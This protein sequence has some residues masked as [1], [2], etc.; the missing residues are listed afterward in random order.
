LWFDSRYFC[1]GVCFGLVNFGNNCV[2]EKTINI[3]APPKNLFSPLWSNKLTGRRVKSG[4]MIF[5][6]IG[7]EVWCSKCRE[8][9]PADTEFFYSNKKYQIG[10]LHEWCKSCC[11]AW[12]RA[13]KEKGRIQ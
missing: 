4:K 10:S 1:V 12:K 6:D 11:Q 13:K 7:R 8:Y 9:W 3:Q 2:T 5:T